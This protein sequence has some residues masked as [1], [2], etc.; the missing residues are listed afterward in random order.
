MMPR[1]APPAW[2]VALVLLTG[3]CA[4]AKVN[5]TDTVGPR[6]ASGEAGMVPLVAPATLRVVSFNV[7]YAIEIDSAIALLR[8]D[9][10]LRG[11]DVLLLQE[12]DESG[13]SRIAGALGM[14]YVYYPATVHP[15]YQRDFGN[16]IL[17]RWPIVE[18]EKIILP[19]HGLWRKTQRAAV[20]ATLQ[21]GSQR[22][23]VY[24]VHFAMAT[25]QTPGHRRAQAERV[26]DDSR[27]WDRI[28]VG[29][30]MN[31]AGMA[32]VFADSGFTWP[33]KHEMPTSHD[34][35]FD[36]IVLR[37]LDLATVGS[38]GVVSDVHGASDHRPVWAVVRLDAPLSLAKGR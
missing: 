26:I 8:Q 35:R 19:Y 38:T 1:F 21:V 33:T 6:Y 5:Y 36:H 30:D 20:A 9:P 22:I 18:D 14:Q 29:G 25:E 3:A 4:T 17:S 2:R 31:D 10:S 37:G 27:G 16:A 12:M 7:E 13:A 28:I 34:W 15:V 32:Q 24:D 23:R 11:A